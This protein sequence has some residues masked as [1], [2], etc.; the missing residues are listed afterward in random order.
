MAVEAASAVLEAAAEALELAELPPT[1]P[2][3]QLAVELAK[4]VAE[5][6]AVLVTPELLA[7]AEEEWLEE[8]ILA[9]FL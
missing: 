6:V 8:S 7:A 1:H 9:P 2:P 4:D 5:E 3:N